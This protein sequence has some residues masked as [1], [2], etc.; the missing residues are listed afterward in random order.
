MLAYWV[1]YAKPYGIIIVYY[2]YCGSFSNDRQSTVVW[3]VDL[4]IR[5]YFQFFFRFTLYPAYRRVGRWNLG[6]LAFLNCG[7]QRVVYRNSTPRIASFLWQWESKPQSHLQSLLYAL[8]APR[9]NEN[10]NNKHKRSRGDEAQRLSTNATAWDLFPDASLG[11][12]FPEAAL[13]T[14]SS[15]LLVPFMVTKQRSEHFY[16]SIPRS[17]DAVQ[18]QIQ[19][20]RKKN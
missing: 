8:P 19:H 3:H 1:F 9:R 4:I 11:P 17:C 20:S 15:L 5:I 14:S 10:N 18:D 13:A 2:I 16:L 7:T 12:S 6:N